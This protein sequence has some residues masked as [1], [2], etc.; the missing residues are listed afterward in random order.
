M[1]EL[2]EKIEALIDGGT[3]YDVIEAVQT[4]CSLKAEHIRENW[5]DEKN[6]KVWDKAATVLSRTLQNDYIRL[7]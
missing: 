1:T 2:E 6:A 3:V 7:L 5:Q 4:V